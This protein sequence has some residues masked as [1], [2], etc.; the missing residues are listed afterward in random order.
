MASSRRPRVFV[1]SVAVERMRQKLLSESF[2][3]AQMALIVLLTGGCGL[4]ASFAMLRYGMVSMALRYPLALGLAYLF[5]LFLIWLW[6]RTNAEDCLDIPDFVS[7]VPS[8]SP[9]DL[10]GIRSG[11]GGDYAGGGASGEFE[12]SAHLPFSG[13]ASAGSDSSFSSVGDAVGSVTDADEFAIPLL[14]IALA[15]GLACA[16]LYVV[17]IAPVLFAEVLVDG[18]LSYALFRHLRGHDPA[19]WLASTFRRTA[20]PFVITA[21]FLAGMGAAMSA[22]APGA[23][24]VGQ[25]VKQA[26]TG[27][28]A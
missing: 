5:F 8:R 15:V 19:H 23:H 11:G 1:R 10:P 25:F 20:V 22:Y 6:L 28:G 21:L 16:S 3:R 18:A 14:A 9:S 4:L 24:S 27:Q 26:R 13:A 2:P 17:Y 12:A 7:G